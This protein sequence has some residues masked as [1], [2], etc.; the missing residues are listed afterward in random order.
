[1]YYRKLTSQKD[2]L[3]LL[4]KVI[5]ITLIV[6][7]YKKFSDYFVI[8]NFTKEYSLFQRRYINLT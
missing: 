2:H 5:D 7:K 4:G 3:T 6:T 8:R 1:M